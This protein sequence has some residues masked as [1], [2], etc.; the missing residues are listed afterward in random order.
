MALSIASTVTRQANAQATGPVTLPA[1]PYT[2]TPVEI[3]NVN[4]GL[5]LDVA[6][7]STADNANVQQ[8][9]CNGQKNQAFFLIPLGGGDYL[10]RAG[11]VGNRDLDVAGMSTADQTNI[12]LFHQHADASSNGQSNPQTF[13]F[14]QNADGS[15]EIRAKFSAKCLDVANA[16]T[17]SGANV[18][19]YTCQGQANQHF[20]L[21]PRLIPMHLI[22]RHSTKCVDVANG[23]L[24]NNANVQQ[25]HCIGQD[26]QLWYA[27]L[28][29]IAPDGNTYYTI[30]S[31]NSGLCLDVAGASTADN[32][33]VQQFGC[34][35]ADNQSFRF[36]ANGD[37]FSIVNKNSGKCVDVAAASTADNANVQQYTC[38]GGDN[39]LFRWE[40]LVQRRV[41]LVQV[42]DDAGN[43][44][45]TIP[46]SDMTHL[47]DKVNALY[48]PM[49][50][51]M[52]YSP[53]SDKMNLN[54]TA[55]HALGDT[56][57]YTCPD[58]TSSTPD[59][60]ANN[61]VLANQPNKTVVFVRPG[62]G[63]SD[64]PL[65]FIAIGEYR[66]GLVCTDVPDETW[67]AHELGHHLGLLH[68]FFGFNTQADADSYLATHSNDISSLDGDLL[69]DTLPSPNLGNNC[70]LPHSPVASVTVNGIAVPT[71]TDNVM[72]YYYNVNPRF[73]AEQSTV[74]RTTVYARGWTAPP[75]VAAPVFVGPYAAGAAAVG[76]A[77]LGILS[78]VPRRRRRTP[79]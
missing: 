6:N 35:G 2:V 39:Q 17:Q 71:D 74:I 38:N 18:Q 4:S 70:L 57:V 20:T 64:G 78:L 56:A 23:S 58:G 36:V 1:F 16:S 8:F 53:A 10:I 11:H 9:T 32:A 50:I 19:Q 55:I 48:Q 13:R 63:F 22:A 43:G 69:G 15:Y 75:P 41:E 42:A 44:R 3:R 54:S 77:A 31:Q 46:D 52:S 45:G 60:C 66:Y 47:I 21:A 61:W 68:T 5:C 25:Y 24:Q 14:Y 51:T 67:L 33:N 79:A 59:V 30:V 62:N 12:Q 34:S 65:Q 49:G 37:Y 27:Q 40:T 29:G 73:T 7:A 28:V 76:F 26:N 72:G